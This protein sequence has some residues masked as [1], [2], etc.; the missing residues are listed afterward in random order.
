MHPNFRLGTLA[1]RLN[2]TEVCERRC[3]APLQIIRGV[4]HVVRQAIKKSSIICTASGEPPV[5]RAEGRQRCGWPQLP[6]NL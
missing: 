2:C 4:I 3:P 5:Y 1:T 6:N